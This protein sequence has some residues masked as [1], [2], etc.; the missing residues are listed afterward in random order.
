MTGPSKKRIRPLASPSS[1]MSKAPREW[2]PTKSSSSTLARTRPPAIFPLQKTWA[3]APLP[4]RLLRLR[5]LR[6]RL[7]LAFDSFGQK[8][9]A[10]FR[11]LETPRGTGLLSFSPPFYDAKSDH[12]SFFSKPRCP[13]PPLHFLA[14]A[15]RTSATI[16]PDPFRDPRQRG[17]RQRRSRCHRCARAIHQRFAARGLP[18]FRRWRRAAHHGFLHCGR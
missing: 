14:C 1:F 16:R 5:L 2:P 11:V 8:S 18:S 7:D 15:T 6:S 3:R 13:T 12:V 10:L 4:R 9:R 17:P